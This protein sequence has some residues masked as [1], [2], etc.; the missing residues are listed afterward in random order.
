M[1]CVERPDGCGWHLSVRNGSAPVYYYLTVREVPRTRPVRPVDRGIQVER[2]YERVDS[3][4][5]ITS[6]LAGELV[7]VRLRI[8]VPDER[9]FVVVDDPLP[10]GLEAVDLSLRTVSPLGARDM[11]RAARTEQEQEEP[12]WYFGSWDS[13]M[14]SVFDYKELRDDRVVYCA[15]MLWK[16]TLHGNL[17]GACHDGGHVRV[18]T[19]TRGRDVQPGA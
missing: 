11:V 4:Q 3:R 7:R 1:D 10:A 13:G 8:T 12:N 6:I 17:S 15:T 14:W 2:W 19:G 5:P 16:G 9:H 18:T